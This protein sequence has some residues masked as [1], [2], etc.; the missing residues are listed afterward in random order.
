VGIALWQGWSAMW[1]PLLLLVPGFL[2]VLPRMP[3]HAPVMG[4]VL[5]VLG[6]T[7]GLAYGVIAFLRNSLAVQAAVVEELKVREAIRRSKV[8]TRGAKG[9]NFV[10]F[11]IAWCLAVVGSG[12]EMPLALIVGLGALRGEQHVLAMVGMLLINF[13]TR[14]LVTPVVL[15]GLSLVYFDQRV[16]QEALDLLLMLGGAAGMGTGGGVVASVVTGDPGAVRDTNAF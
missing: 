11:L 9:R 14:T 10:V 12:L 13:V 1:L 7:G 16:R 15:I 4:G 3:W 5:L 6:F 2:L 8:L